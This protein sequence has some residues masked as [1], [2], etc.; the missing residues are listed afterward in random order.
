MF[1]FGFYFVSE[2]PVSG[3]DILVSLPLCFLYS[4]EQNH[5]IWE[6]Q[7]LTEM[8]PNIICLLPCYML[9]NHCLLPF[10]SI[11][12][13]QFGFEWMFQKIPDLGILSWIRTNIN[14]SNRKIMLGT[15]IRYWQGFG[16]ANVLLIYFPH[17]ITCL[18]FMILYFRLQLWDNNLV[19]RKF[20][21]QSD[22]K[23]IEAD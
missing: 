22:P 19:S 15:K 12:F 1:Y 13:M 2:F 4:M 9:F 8:V 17:L 5:S 11:N 7:M 21:F 14:L 18:Q 6:K 10:I 3:P 16:L 20:P 23:V